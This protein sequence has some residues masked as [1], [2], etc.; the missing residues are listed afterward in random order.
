MRQLLLISNHGIWTVGY[1]DI[2]EADSYAQN[3]G[4]V[5]YTHFVQGV[6]AKT[7][8]NNLPHRDYPELWERHWV[9]LSTNHKRRGFCP[10]PSLNEDR[11]VSGAQTWP[12]VS[13]IAGRLRPRN[14][15][16]AAIFELGAQ[17]LWVRECPRISER[18]ND[19]WQWHQY[20]LQPILLQVYKCFPW[21][22][23]PFFQR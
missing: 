9:C 18:D 2:V 23:S 16:A 7:G 13:R 11:W 1:R 15:S 10:A 6:G 5:R 4:L 22:F 12:I 21:I 14:D 17:L 19:Y 8:P 20:L 3:D